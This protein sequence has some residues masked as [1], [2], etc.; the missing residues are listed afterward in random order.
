MEN[1]RSAL[2]MRLGAAV[3]GIGMLS[4]CTATAGGGNTGLSPTI[5]QACMLAAAGGAAIG[6]AADEGNRLRGALVGGVV[7]AL[8][9]CTAGAIIDNRRR[10]YASNSEFIAGQIDLT[11]ET[12]TQLAEIN[13]ATA[14]R[15]ETH[16]AE[17]TR[18]EQVVELAEADRE[19]A[20]VQ[21][22]SAREERRLTERRIEVLER[23]VETQRLA[24][25]R[26][27]EVEPSKDGAEVDVA[28]LA[29]EVETMEAYVEDLRRY[30]E[31]LAA[32][33][34]TIGQFT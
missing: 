19:A 22:G 28:E 24:L 8:A 17:I 30:S 23:E 27:G 5:S 21:L 13:A 34:D 7:G 18:L 12:N 10:E 16:Q 4:G 32:Q 29:A 1:L 6:A 9:G 20:Q 14:A 26:F 31:T 3:A 33:E 11:R 2:V 15:I 25:E